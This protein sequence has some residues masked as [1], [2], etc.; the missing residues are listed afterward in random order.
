MNRVR[1]GASSSLDGLI[2]LW[3]AADLKSQFAD[4]TARFIALQS[5]VSAK[6]GAV[7]SVEEAAQVKADA[8]AYAAST[9][10]AADAVLA[11]AQARESDAKLAVTRA[12]ARETT[13]ADQEAKGI[14]MQD[15]FAKKDGELSRNMIVREASVQAR[16]EAVTDREAKLDADNA[17]LAQRKALLDQKLASLGAIKV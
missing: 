5:D 4:E 15:A 11:S 2:G 13:A 8:D 14:A 16:E 10:G 17:T 6:L 12:V 7:E 3:N 9:K 1:A